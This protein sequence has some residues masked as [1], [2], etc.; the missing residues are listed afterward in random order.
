VTAGCLSISIEGIGAV[1][2][3]F[4]E[5]GILLAECASGDLPPKLFKLFARAE[6]RIGGVDD[7]AKAKP[8]VRATGRLLR[9]MVKA[10]DRWRSRGRI[11]GGCAEALTARLK[12]ASQRA[13]L[14]LKNT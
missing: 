13:A 2:C 5:P 4:E 6:S 1:R 3:I 10:I 7:A 14:W 12:G 8:S 11:S 9:K